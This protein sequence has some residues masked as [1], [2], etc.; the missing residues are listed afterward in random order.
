[1]KGLETA[2]RA[3]HEVTF[4]LPNH[5]LVFLE[6]LLQGCS[7]MKKNEVHTAYHV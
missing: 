6:T 4:H 7:P 2:R 1:M 3:G 5:L